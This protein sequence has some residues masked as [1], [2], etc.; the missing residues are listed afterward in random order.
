M[1]MEFYLRSYY[2][3]AEVD[4]YAYLT[5]MWLQS[6]VFIVYLGT[7]SVSLTIWNRMVL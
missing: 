5:V 7:L 6:Y 3:T 4:F 2:A 1:V